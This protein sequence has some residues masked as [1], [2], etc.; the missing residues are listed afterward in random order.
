MDNNLLH[1]LQHSLGVDK[2]GNGRR[3]RNHY[4]AGGADVEKCRALVS[5]GF[6]E[7]HP[8]NALCGGAPVFTVTPNGIDAVALES[9]APVKM[10]RGQRRYRAYLSS[11][12]DGTFGEWLKNH[13]WDDYRARHGV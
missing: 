2:Y 9:P 10:T 8:S 12:S 11:G 1:I 4:V 5:A 3:Y 13:Y 7:E 6:M